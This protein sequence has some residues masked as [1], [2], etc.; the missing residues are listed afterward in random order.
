[1][2]INTLWGRLDKKRV[3]LRRDHQRQFREIKIA[4]KKEHM[5][6]LLK[7]L[8]R[9]K[10]AGVFQPDAK[11]KLV[12][13]KAIGPMVVGLGDDLL[14]KDEIAVMVRGPKFCVMR[15]MNEERFP[16]ECEKSYYKL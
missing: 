11:T 1:M 6:K 2:F 16:M 12:P 14:D 8:Q 7:E 10:K 3:K 13:G 5:M 9:Y 15:V 4:G